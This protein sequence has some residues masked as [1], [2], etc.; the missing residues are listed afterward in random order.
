MHKLH[1]AAAKSTELW[2]HLLQTTNYLFRA[3]ITPKEL[4]AIGC[5]CPLIHLVVTHIVSP[6]TPEQFETA[7]TLSATIQ[8][9]GMLLCCTLISLNTIRWQLEEGYAADLLTI[10]TPRRWLIA[11]WLAV[12]LACVTQLAFHLLTLMSDCLA[13]HQFGP[14]P[15]HHWSIYALN[16]ALTL[17]AV[18]AGGIV[19]SLF[20]T[21]NSGFIYLVVILAAWINYIPEPFSYLLPPIYL[22]DAKGL[23]VAAG[24]TASYA[25]NTKGWVAA[26]LTTLA[27]SVILNN[28]PSRRFVLTRLRT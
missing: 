7:R 28:I 20:A 10:T 11:N 22:L 4:V 15:L 3:I 13:H 5:L 17:L 6:H 2:R 19:F 1:P 9:G 23:L 18:T 21:K 27:Y 26:A 14:I 16:G 8:W 25:I 12:W 24:S